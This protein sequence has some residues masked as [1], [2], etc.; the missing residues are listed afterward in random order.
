MSPAESTAPLRSA[1]ATSP[2]HVGLAVRELGRSIAFYCEAFALTLMGEGQSHGIRY[3]F[4]GDGARVTVTLWEQPMPPGLH[5][6]AFETAS[7]DDLREAEA[8]L[9]R[10]GATMTYEGIVLHGDGATSGGL[11]FTDPDGLRLEIY[12]ASGVT[13]QAPVGG[14][15]TCGF[16]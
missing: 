12:A 7:A 13:G 8:R 2:G 16:F 6:L 9:A 14:A 4:L 10:L 1:P 15:P 5:H 11:Y 3:A